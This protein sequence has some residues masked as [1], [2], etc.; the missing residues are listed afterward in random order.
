MDRVDHI[1]SYHH[2]PIS[3]D[4]YHNADHNN[5]AEPSVSLSKLEQLE[6]VKMHAVSI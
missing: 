1:I 6:K 3:Y 4:S 2:R 5:S